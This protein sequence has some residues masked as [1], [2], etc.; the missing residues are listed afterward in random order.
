MKAI[1][2]LLVAS[3]AVSAASA[4]AD[5]RLPSGPAVDA[6]PL[7]NASSGNVALDGP[8]LAFAYERVKCDGAAGCSC[9]TV[10]GLRIARRRSD[11]GSRSVADVPLPEPPTALRVR[12][13]FGFVA[14]A[15]EGVYVLDLRIPEAPLLAARY[16]TEDRPTAL[17]VDGDLLFVGGD[18]GVE[19]V[20]VSDPFH[21]RHESFLVSPTGAVRGIAVSGGFAY[22][23]ESAG[24]SRLWI[25]DVRRPG[26]PAVLGLLELERPATGLALRGPHVLLAGP[27]GMQVVDVRDPRAPVRVTTLDTP[28][29]AGGIVV[30]GR[31]AFL[32]TARGAPAVDADPPGASLVTMVDLREPERPVVAGQS[33]VRGGGGFLGWRTH[34]LAVDRGDVYLGVSLVG[35]PTEPCPDASTERI[36]VVRR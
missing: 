2:T 20:D 35:V 33:R 10:H 25:A 26:V 32:S 6:G 27:D 19:L 29:A 34:G 1:H 9:E 36:L 17:Q 24:T 30:H 15:R 18:L 11:G 12:A 13:G 4:A 14:L 23:I 3:I 31:H 8:L 7:S 21:P 16:P 5:P 22:A 28:A